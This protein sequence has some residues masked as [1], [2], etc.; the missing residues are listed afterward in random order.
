VS[1]RFL[2]V[3]LWAYTM[4]GAGITPSLLAAFLWPRATGA[5]AVASITTGIA[6]TILWELRPLV[7][8]VETVYPALAG[9]LAALVL[10]SLATRR[11]PAAAPLGEPPR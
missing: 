3:A 8:G 9:S 10:V 4:Y 1:N 6:V 5:G 2:A 7:P 11:P